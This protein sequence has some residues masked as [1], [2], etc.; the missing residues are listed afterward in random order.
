[1]RTE[2]GLV[3]APQSW[4]VRCKARVGSR[5]G[6]VSLGG[7]FERLGLDRRIGGRTVAEGKIGLLTAVSEHQQAPHDETH[8]LTNAIES[9]LLHRFLPLFDMVFVASEQEELL[10]VAQEVGRLLGS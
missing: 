2:R 4:A 1:M 6:H 8:I 5:A 3:H 9:E 7:A 10:L